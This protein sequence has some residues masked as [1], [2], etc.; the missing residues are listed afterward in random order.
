MLYGDRFI[1]WN[2]K[3]Y[4]HAKNNIFSMYIDVLHLPLIYG[5]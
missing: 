4:I 1:Y 5:F 3:S 2:V